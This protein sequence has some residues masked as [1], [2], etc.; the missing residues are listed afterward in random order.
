MAIAWKGEMSCPTAYFAAI[1]GSQVASCGIA[2][3]IAISNIKSVKSPFIVALMANVFESS[4]IDL[5]LL[6]FKR[7]SEDAVLVANFSR[8]F[9]DSF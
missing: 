1:E 7:K 8:Q 5:F 2:A 9:I 6:S 3:I 4:I